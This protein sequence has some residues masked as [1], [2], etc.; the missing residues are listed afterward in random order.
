MRPLNM[1]KETAIQ[2]ATIVYLG[3]GPI[4]KDYTLK[5][6]TKDHALSL[7]THDEAS[8]RLCI[9]VEKIPGDILLNT[10]RYRAIVHRETDCPGAPDVWLYEPNGPDS[11][12]NF[13]T[14]NPPVDSRIES[15]I[16]TLQE[17][18]PEKLNTYL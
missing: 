5:R 12:L 14:P 18:A 3:K 6:I 2:D 9:M 4:S 10:C 8:G 17:L 11:D 16:N 13:S 15:A 1:T 7:I